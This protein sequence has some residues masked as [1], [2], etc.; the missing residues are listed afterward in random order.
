LHLVP[1]YPAL[2][3]PRPKSLRNACRT[4]TTI[5]GQLHLRDPDY[6]Y[7]DDSTACP[8]CR[9]QLKSSVNRSRHIM[10][11]PEC[12]TQHMEELKAIK[13]RRREE[14]YK[15]AGSSQP[16][17][18]WA[19][20]NPRDASAHD[21]GG[22]RY[23]DPRRWGDNGRTCHEP[24][25]E[26]FPISTVGQPISRHRTYPQN[27]RAYLHLCGP[28]ANRDLFENAEVLMTTGL[29]GKSRTRHLKSPA[30]SKSLNPYEDQMLTQQDS[31][32]EH[33]GARTTH[34]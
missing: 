34:S 8:Y 31:T 4:Y 18:A 6:T 10:M 19:T 2:N 17:P 28:L 16:R 23:N 30:V 25:I 27:L 32:E 3:M 1:V 33:P 15:I 24:C 13:R 29:S 20:G 21:A 22:P 9:L 5:L 11:R 7:G 12:R 14:E 26:H